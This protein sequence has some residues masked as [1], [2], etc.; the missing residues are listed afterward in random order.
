MAVMTRA[1]AGVGGS[2]GRAASGSAK[3]LV[4]FGVAVACLALGTACT[5]ET[6]E[7]LIRAAERHIAER[8]YRTAQIE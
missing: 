5:T 8:D 1:G 3:A 4:A 2:P 7:G 6:P